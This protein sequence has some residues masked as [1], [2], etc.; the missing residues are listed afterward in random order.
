MSYTW[1]IYNSIKYGY[2]NEERRTEMKG[3]EKKISLTQA[4]F[5]WWKP[6]EEEGKES[7]LVRSRH[8]FQKCPNR[9]D[10][11]R[12]LSLPD[13]RHLPTQMAISKPGLSYSW[14]TSWGSL[15]GRLEIME[16]TLEGSVGRVTPRCIHLPILHTSALCTILWPGS[17]GLHTWGAQAFSRGRRRPAS[18]QL[19]WMCR[20]CSEHTAFGEGLLIPV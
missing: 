3:K 15:V 8:K 14:W 12:M 17:G 10:H 4:G 5:E 11:L 1:N 2:L 19:C 20:V 7:G 6:L 16:P 18:W 13:G 9:W